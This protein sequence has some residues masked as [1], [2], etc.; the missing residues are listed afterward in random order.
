MYVHIA[1][2]YHG[3][4]PEAAQVRAFLRQIKR[5]LAILGNA[6]SAQDEHISQVCTRGQMPVA[7]YLLQ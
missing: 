1:P 3:L 2:C 7:K 5:S 6:F 4:A